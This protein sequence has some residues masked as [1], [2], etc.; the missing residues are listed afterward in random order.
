MRGN[1]IWTAVI[2][3]STLTPVASARALPPIKPGPGSGVI[4]VQERREERREERCDLLQLREKE[5]RDRME[6]TRRPE[7]RE[8]LRLQLQETRERMD[9]CRR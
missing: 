2:M 5:L 7:E 9:R 4:A 6:M 8:A 1:G 3:V